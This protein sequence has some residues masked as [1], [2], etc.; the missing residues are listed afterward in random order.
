M[1]GSR[2]KHG[3]RRVSVWMGI[4]KGRNMLVEHV[5]FVVVIAQEFALG[6]N[7]GAGILVQ[8]RP[9]HRLI[10]WQIMRPCWWIV[11]KRIWELHE[12]LSAR[13]RTRCNGG[14]RDKNCFA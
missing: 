4:I 12:I 9:A 11:W 13:S 6:R 10:S 8:S 5:G 7:F 14:Y 1:A 2:V 3:V